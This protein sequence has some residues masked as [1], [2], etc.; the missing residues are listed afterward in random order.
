MRLY[1]A[2]LLDG[3]AP[4]ATRQRGLLQ[5]GGLTLLF[6]LF[7]L[8]L[9]WL[10]LPQL[11]GL[12]PWAA[13]AVS[14]FFAMLMLLIAVLQYRPASRRP[15]LEPVRKAFLSALWFGVA[16]LAAIFAARMGFTLGVALFLAVGSLGYGM[17]LGRL[18][19]GLRKA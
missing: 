2:E 15:W 7:H 14:G 12:P 16:G 8:G 10:T 18:W 11:T 17:S 3:E 1:W 4:L 9:A 6:Q 5:L 13:W 19:F